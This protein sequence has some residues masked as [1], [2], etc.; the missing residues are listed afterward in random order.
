VFLFR[1]SR[2][3]ER[4]AK[5]FAALREEQEAAGHYWFRFDPHV[6]EAANRVLALG[7]EEQ[8]AF[9]M[10]ALEKLKGTHQSYISRH[11]L[12]QTVTAVL[13]RRLPFGE[14]DLLYMLAWSRRQPYN[15]VRCVP[16][17][18]RA[19][20]NYLKD[21]E[22]TPAMQREIG[23]LADAVTIGY[24]DAEA[25]R[26]SVRLRELGDLNGASVPLVAG[27]AWSDV[28]IAEIEASEAERTAAWVS[29]LDHCAKAGGARPSA[30]WQKT[31]R[32]LAGRLGIGHFVDA[33][34]R[35]FP[36]VD[37]PRN[38]VLS[39]TSEWMPDPN[40]LIEDTN[41]DVL[42]GLAWT[43]ALAASAEE[44]VGRDVARTLTRLAV[45]AYRKV[46]QQGP[47]C[48]RVGNA[49]VWAL[50]AMPGTEG[51]SELAVLKAKAKFGSARKAIE[52]ALLE[53]AG[54]SG[55]PLD[56]V[57]ELSV[58]TYGFTGVG[59]RRE[60]FGGYVAEAVVVGTNAVELRW[61][62]PDGRAQK[63]VP[64]AVK[65][66]FPEELAAMKR[67]L[68]DV[69]QALPAQ[70]D[71]IE[72]SYLRTRSWA[73]SAW[74]ERYLDHP[75]VGTLARRLIWTFSGAS[76]AV[77]GIF[78]DG[79]LVDRRGR[80]LDGLDASTRVELW[81]PI[82][83]SPDEV[84]AWRD[85]LAELQIKQ[86]FKQAH[87]EVY[88]LTDAERATGVY[89]NRFAAHFLRQHQFNALCVARGWKNK[90]RLMV[91][92][93]FPPATLDLAAWGLRAEFWIE[94]IGD[95]YGTD[96]N[97][98]GTYLYLSTDQV[99]FYASGANENLAHAY[100]GGYVGY[101]AA[102]TSE[103]IPLESV[104]PLVFSE[105]MRDVDLFV[106]VASVGND[107]SWSDGGPEGRF[108][109]YWAGYSFG[110]LSET[111]KTRREVLERVVPRLAIAGRCSFEERF[112]VVRGDLR[113]YRIHLGSGNILMKPND[114]YLCIV[115]R[116]G[117]GDDA[118]GAILPFEGDGTL[119][120][121]LSKAIMLAED[122]K[123]QDPTIVR[124][125]KVQ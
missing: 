85:W 76:G 32:K 28:A 97:P 121:I 111:A 90:L 3:E 78:H 116:R 81:H 98:T 67:T 72:G 37:R 120:V 95:D 26:W 69:Q 56:E 39:L 7:P 79:H 14:D 34:T 89:S 63:S 43:C 115:T 59:V 110:D 102:N 29:L 101:G 41:A 5:T 107:P 1:R 16:Q 19:L 106:G 65:E 112:L 13:K 12:H 75:L 105:A 17:V 96:T 47:R 125:I 57:E 55:I 124:Q 86:P 80:P 22:V 122:R 118:G 25:R 10:E 93:D 108:R 33:V 18:I 50:G 21:N 113:T 15:Y 74:R 117:L 46:P 35:W 20:G 119:A 58:P 92:D 99:R 91:D 2:R 11:S 66:G 30:T 104:P 38:A 88:L 31:S 48:V 45:S 71:R 6:S 82:G 77:A 100:G 123:I 94:G 4:F 60:D 49:C 114:Q 68:K 83:E 40:L 70:R 8:R 64:K 23:R 62:R 27:E 51:I 36:L 42:K 9:V 54:R 73:Y 44:G 87:R 52:K 109:D 103:P 24:A 84:L 53:A 61:V